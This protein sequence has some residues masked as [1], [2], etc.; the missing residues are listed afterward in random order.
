MR[1]TNKPEEEFQATGLDTKFAPAERAPGEVVERQHRLLASLPYVKDLMDAIPTA[2][3]VLN[4]ERQIVFT[5]D[6]VR[7]FIPAGSEPLTGKRHGEAM[8]CTHAI[9]GKRPGEATGCIRAHTCAS[10]CGTTVFCRNCGAVKAVLNSQNSK[11]PDEQECRMTCGEN[12][13]PLDLRVWARPIEIEGEPFTVFS[14]K[15]ISDEKRKEALERIFFHDILNTASGVKGL[16]DLIANAVLS[17]NETTEIAGMLADSS[18]HLVDEI[19]SQRLLSAAEQG[20]LEVASEP[21]QTIAVLHKLTRHFHSFCTEKWQHL[22][23]AESAVDCSFVSDPVLIQRVLINL[24]I[25]ALEAVGSGETV[26]LNAESTDDSVTFTVHNHAVIA[27]E[28]RQQLFTR[29]FSTKGTGRGLGTYS[30]K[31]LTER[32]LNG[33]V[34]FVSHKTKGTTF[35]VTYPRVPAIRH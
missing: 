9:I 4:K 12:A 18:S 24:T 29:S 23:I 1:T 26:T 20:H 15:D 25:N 14:I 7:H 34:S 22:V 31:L 35:K 8:H 30:I 3:M 19:R 10:G 2:A 32:Y 5:N 27:P 6:E 13:E 17:S 28:V 16:A 21:L 33:R 11:R